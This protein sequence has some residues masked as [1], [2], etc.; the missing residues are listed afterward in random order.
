MWLSLH[1]CKTKALVFV[2]IRKLYHTLSLP[3]TIIADSENLRLV[4]DDEFV[5][6]VGM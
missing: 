4:D 3:C 5:G 2:N 1:I 6:G